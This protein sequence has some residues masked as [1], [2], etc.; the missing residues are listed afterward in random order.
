MNKFVYPFLNYSYSEFYEEYQ[1]EGEDDSEE[2]EEEEYNE[3]DEDLFDIIEF[4][5][6][7][8]LEEKAKL[9]LDVL[10]EIRTEPAEIECAVCLENIIISGT[11]IKLPCSHTFHDTCI[12]EWGKNHFTCPT[13]RANIPTKNI[14]INNKC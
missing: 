5:A 7:R 13:C 8:Q 6:M 3:D 2:E 11:Q 1:N 10:P 4:M 14:I 12:L 9:C